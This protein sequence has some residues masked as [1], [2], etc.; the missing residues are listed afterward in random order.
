MFLEQY[1]EFFGLLN[2]CIVSN[3]GRGFFIRWN[4]WSI[5]GNI[6]SW[7]SIWLWLDYPL[8]NRWRLRSPSKKTALK[9]NLFKNKKKKLGEIKL[10]WLCKVLI[11]CCNFVNYSQ[12]CK[13]RDAKPPIWEDVPPLKG[14][15]NV[16]FTE[17]DWDI[18]CN[19]CLVYIEHPQQWN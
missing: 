2:C 19:V 4:F 18:S 1:F 9:M 16:T 11:N 12:I 6:W 13:D 3:T 7:S 15:V 5:K 8:G 17:I 10:K 14:R